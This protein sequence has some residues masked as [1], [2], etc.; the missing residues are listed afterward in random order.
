M[1]SLK[2]LAVVFSITLFLFSCSDNDTTPIDTSAQEQDLI[3]TWLLIEVTQD[4]TIDTT[5]EGI[6]VTGKITS[7]GKEIDAQIEFNENPNAFT[8]SGGYIDEITITFLGQS[9]TDDVPISINNSVS[10]GTWSLDQG[11]LTLGENSNQQ[12]VNITELTD[13]NLKFEFDIEETG[14]LQGFTGTI[15][16]TVKMTFTKQ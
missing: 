5:F 4:G 10:Q 3:G 6:P 12:T 15:N 16:S 9:F 2:N 7:F 14:T 13:T 8:G 1:K 11:I